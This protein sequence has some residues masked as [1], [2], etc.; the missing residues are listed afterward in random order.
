MESIKGEWVSPI[1]PCLVKRQKQ[2]LKAKKAEDSVSKPR[3]GIFLHFFITKDSADFFIKTGCCSTLPFK[4]SIL[5][6][7]LY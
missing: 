7:F 5:Q 6:N 3:K 4:N 1:P 2:R